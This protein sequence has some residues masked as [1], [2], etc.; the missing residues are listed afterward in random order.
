MLGA[1]ILQIPSGH[2]LDETPRTGPPLWVG[3]LALGPMPDATL[4]GM[5]PQRELPEVRQMVVESVRAEVRR[6][7]V[8]TPPGALRTLA[9]DGK[10]LWRGTRGGGADGQ[11]QGAGRGHRVMRALLTSARPRVV[12]EHRTLGAEENEIGAVAAFW[13]QLLQTSGRLARWEVVTLE[14]GYG[15]RKHATLID[16]A[17]A[18]DVLGLKENQPDLLREAERL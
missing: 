8:V 6:Q 9:I 14:A 12:L 5:L 17:G 7:R 15:S 13:A 1:L 16:A 2:R 11:A 18:G 10:W 4:Q 3:E